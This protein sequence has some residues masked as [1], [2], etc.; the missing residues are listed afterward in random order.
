M[1]NQQI[2]SEYS[3]FG[4]GRGMF[5]KKDIYLLIYQIVKVTFIL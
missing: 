5:V 2:N 1:I 3:P 4:R